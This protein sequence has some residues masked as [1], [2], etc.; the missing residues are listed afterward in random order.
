M[1]RGLV[2]A[3]LVANLL[4]LAWT[5]GWLDALPGGSR[6]AEREPERIDRQVHRDAVQLIAPTAASAALQA[7]AALRTHL[8]PPTSA[9]AG[10]A[11]ASMS[12]AERP[13]C[14]EAGP[15]AAGEVTAAERGLRELQWP[16]LNW[17]NVKSE[18]GGAFIAYQ[19]RFADDAAMA[20]RR[21]ELRRQQIGVEELRNSPDL[22]P[23]LSF[24][25]FD[26][27]A[28]ADD[29]VAQL[30][31]RGVKNARVVTI[32]APVVVTLLRVERADAA[33]AARLS[34]L[35]LPPAGSG[36]KPCAATP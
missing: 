25:R 15:F 16:G 17:V 36:F 32:A 13:V 34:Q 19:G 24:G 18:R 29:A 10:D 6:Q 30:A 8:P 31:Q 9:A 26:S 5:L 22:Q 35:N 4:A 12:D 20:R 14:L 23:G 1:L 2:A 11:P 33:L 21:E 27:R 28:A 7:A 3:L